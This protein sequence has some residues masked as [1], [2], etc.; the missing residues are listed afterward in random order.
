MVTI[1]ILYYWQVTLLSLLL[2]TVSCGPHGLKSSGRI[3]NDDNILYH[4]RW[5][6]LLHGVIL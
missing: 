3:I 6:I 2:K 4:I 1:R 5:Y